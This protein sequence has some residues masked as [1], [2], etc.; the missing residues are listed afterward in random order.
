MTRKEAIQRIKLILGIPTTVTT[1]PRHPDTVLEYELYESMKDVVLDSEDYLEFKDIRLVEDQWR[2]A[3]PSNLLKMHSVHNLYN[4]RWKNVNKFDGGI[5][6]FYNGFDITDTDN[7]IY[8]YCKE[9]GTM[10]PEHYH[11]QASVESSAKPPVLVDYVG[12]FGITDTGDEIDQFD[13]YFNKGDYNAVGQIHYLESMDWKIGDGASSQACTAVSDATGI[14]GAQ[15][16]LTDTSLAD[17]MANLGVNVGDII[18]RDTDK[19]WAVVRRMTGKTVFYD[20]VHGTASNFIALDFYSIGTANKITLTNYALR[21]DMFDDLQG[22][23]DNSFD[24]TSVYTGLAGTYTATTFTP[25]GGYSAVSD[26]V[27]GDVIWSTTSDSIRT[28][29]EVTAINS[30]TGV[31]TIYPRWSHGPPEPNQTATISTTPTYVPDNAET[32]TIVRGDEYTVE[33]KFP[34]LDGLLVKP[35]PASSD[36]AGEASVRLY[37]YPMPEIP[38]YDQD[39]LS[40]NPTYNQSVIANCIERARERETG[41]TRSYLE[42]LEHARAN[43]FELNYGSL[44]NTY[45]RPG[46]KTQPRVIISADVS[47]L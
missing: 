40:L 23:V 30:T 27:V 35:V 15:Y 28:G 13:Y 38:L 2:Y 9:P 34:T 1:D 39:E 19:C 7:Q 21:R 17:T 11:G 36:A 29:G 33:D 45:V 31:V 25:S 44:G 10:R 43:R 22:G 14:T 41:K 16:S 37:F 26:T 47:N 8:W 3:L 18:S 4:D 32:A 42:E 12:N 5:S 6:G 20:R 24:V 46:A